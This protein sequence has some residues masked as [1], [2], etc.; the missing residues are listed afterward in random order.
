MIVIRDRNSRGWTQLGWLDSRHSFSFGDY[1]DPAH[2]G[3]RALRVINEDRVIPGAG[4]PTH[5]HRDMEILSI[6]LSGALEHKDSLGN[7]SIIRPGEIQRMS[8]GTGITHSE[9]NH[10]NEEPLHFVQIWILPEHQGLPP[11]YEQKPWPS[12]G[13]GDG[14]M[15]IGDR[16]A[17]DGAVTIHQD[18]RLYLARL[19]AG[20]DLTHELPAERHAWLQVTGG[21]VTLVG[22]ELRAGDGVA[23]SDEPVSI[24]L[25]T[26]T[27]A[28]VLL[29]DLA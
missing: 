18:V 13:K 23:I 17:T 29:F 3:F 10:S 5:G 15:L 4:F 9:F 19:E 2:M 26:N 11:G 8:A 20:Q 14:L 22:E 21:I 6:V 24:E 16:H 7:G 27:G 25:H 28:D 12:N 1:R